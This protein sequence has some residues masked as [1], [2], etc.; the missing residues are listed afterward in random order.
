MTQS[1]I[2]CE[3][4]QR[5]GK[6]ALEPVECSFR[7]L[8]PRWN[9]IWGNVKIICPDIYCCQP[10]PKWKAVFVNLNPCSRCRAKYF[11]GKKLNGEYEIRVEQVQCYWWTQLHNSTQAFVKENVF[12]VFFYIVKWY[13][14]AIVCNKVSTIIE[15]PLFPPL[16]ALSSLIGCSF[17]FFLF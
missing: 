11:R 3:L 1:H 8:L 9:S 12:N 17:S 15:E 13:N 4:C 16:T 7:N 10:E 6:Q 14:K 5:F 2:V